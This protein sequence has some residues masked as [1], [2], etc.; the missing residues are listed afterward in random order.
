MNKDNQIVGYW[1]NNVLHGLIGEV[2]L[3]C[4]AERKKRGLIKQHHITGPVTWR[5]TYQGSLMCM[6]CGKEFNQHQR[7][8]IVGYGVRELDKNGKEETHTYCM[9]CVTPEI[10][11]GCYDGLTPFGRDDDYC[12]FVDRPDWQI[13]LQTCYKCGKKLK[14]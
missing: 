11:I 10:I 8:P 6:S 3:D 2:H 5:D 13:Q 9:D 4:Y 14:I 7:A 1:V 12:E